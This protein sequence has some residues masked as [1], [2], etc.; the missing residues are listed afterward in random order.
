MAGESE[1]SILMPCLNE[2]ETLRT[3]IV[4]AQEWAKMS[5]TRAE[6]IVADNGSTDG[7]QEIAFAAGARV[8]NVSSRGYGSALLEGAKGARS[9]FIIMGDSDD[10]YDFSKLDLFLGEL[11]AGSQLVMGN[12]FAG[13]IEAGAM[14]WKNKHIGNPVLS[15]IGRVLFGISVRDFHCGLRGFTKEAFVKMDLRT[16][17]MEFASEMVIKAQLLGLTITEVPTTLSKDGR[18]RPPHLKPWRDGWRHLRFMFSLS[19]KFLFIV[20]GFGLAFGGLLFYVPL[21]LGPVNLGAVQF[22]I[23]SLFVSQALFIV[24]CVSV[25]LGTAIR[26]FATREGLLPTNKFINKVRTIP[27]FEVGTL[28]GLIQVAGSVCLGIDAITHWADSNFG[29]LSPDELIRQISLA[30]S[31]LIVGGISICASLLFGFLSLPLRK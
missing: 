4:K 27:I 19:P 13:G 14:P 28:V 2:A 6:I 18:S 20:P 22:S 9:N 1:L 26:I 30:S 16:T 25:V 7:S 11:R 21:L 5:G 3:C 23:N 12:R 10:S 17:G 29:L 8:V 24:G 31:L 15:W